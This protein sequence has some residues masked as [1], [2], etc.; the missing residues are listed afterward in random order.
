[1]LLESD[2][3]YHV[4]NQGNNRQRIF[5]TAENYLFFIQKM[6]VHLLPYAD[7]LSYCLMPNHFH[8]QLK[9]KDFGVEKG[10]SATFISDDGE[11][12]SITKISSGIR[13]LLSSY[14]RAINRQENRSG[15]LFRAGTKMKPAYGADSNFYLKI[16][17]NQPFSLF[18]PYVE[19]CF[20]Y[21]HN[22][23]VKAGLV[24]KAEDWKYSSASDYAGLRDS[25]LCNYDLAEKIL[26]IKRKV[27]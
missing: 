14:T 10:R 8:W 20:Y 13:T 1:M 21:I 26:N 17:S 3:V 22:N 11:V 15:S 18:L 16:D 4:F 24:Q 25:K 23:P 27:H 12:S 5:Y 2:V 7:L 9:P 6:R 19:K